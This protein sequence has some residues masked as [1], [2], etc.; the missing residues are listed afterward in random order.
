MDLSRLQQQL[1]QPELAPV[2]SWN[3][4]FCG[5]L[6]ILIDVDGHWY[7]QGS[8]IARLSLVQLFARVL[9]YQNQQYFLQTPVEK[10]RIQVADVPFLITESQWQHTA[11]GSELWLTTN[12]G[13][14][15]PL[16][17]AYPL[18]LR[19]FAGQMLPYLQ[20]WRGLQARLHRNLY[21]QLLAE[22]ELNETPGVQAGTSHI[23][24]TIQSGGQPFLL[25]EETCIVAD[26]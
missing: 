4:K 17:S 8:K 16:S 26:S 1:Q 3:P 24:C 25:A 7:Y 5:D 13:D 22:A 6:P 10:V 14:R 9:L 23:R 19:P 11:A 21:Y 15:L 12:L 18:L 20:L 2:E